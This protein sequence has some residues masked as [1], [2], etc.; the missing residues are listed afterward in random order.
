MYLSMGNVA[1]TGEV[2]L[3]F[4]DFERGHRLRLNGTATIDGRDP[5]IEDYPEAPFVVRVGCARCSQTAR[6]TSIVTPW[7]AARR[8]CRALLA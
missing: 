5:L 7:C 1:Q 3:L 8:S 4:I 6:A 2:G